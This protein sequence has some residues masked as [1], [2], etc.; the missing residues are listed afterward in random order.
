MYNGEWE[1]TYLITEANGN[2]Y[3]FFEVNKTL[4]AIML[5]SETQSN[6]AELNTTK[7]WKNH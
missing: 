5:V 4:H 2:K 7:L 6:T 3:V 1:N